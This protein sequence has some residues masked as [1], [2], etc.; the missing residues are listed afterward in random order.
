MP[1][2]IQKMSQQLTDKWGELNKGQ[3]T[4]IGILSLVVVSIIAFAIYFSTRS[5]WVK[6]ID[7]APED[8]KVISEKLDEKKIVYTL[9]EDA[10]EIY[11]KEKDKDQAILLL[12][13][14]GYPKKG[15]DLETLITEESDLGTTTQ[16]RTLKHQKALQTELERMIELYPQVDK[17][18]VQLVLAEES[19]FINQDEES[20]AAV[21]L[22]TNQ[23]LTTKE[24]NG[25]AHLIMSSVKALN[26]ENINIVANGKLLFGE[27]QDPTSED[28]DQRFALQKAKE[29]DIEKKVKEVL[30]GYDDVKVAAQLKLDFDK[31]KDQTI[32]YEPVNKD[33]GE[34][35]VVEESK[36]KE[37]LINGDGSVPAGVTQNPGATPDMYPNGQNSQSTYKKDDQKTTRVWNE[38]RTEVDKAIG[39]VISDESSVAVTVF[40][41][42]TYY[43]EELEKSGELQDKSWETFQDEVKST[44]KTLPVDAGV[45]DQIQK[46]TGIKDVNVVIKERPV[47]VAKIEKTIPVKDY[48]S[49]GVVLLLIIL[50]GIFII[51]RNQPEEEFILTPDI[52][53]DE[54]LEQVEN[55]VPVEEIDYDE[56]GSEVK[57]QIDK[58]VE[59]KPEA[60]AQ[61]LRN[62]LNEDWE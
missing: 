62:W 49:M 60:V 55:T 53:V 4:K 51:R 5:P 38:K 13:E 10:K 7:A 52:V 15:Y 47:F 54:I 12:A 33:T 45:I 39:E 27:D 11:V 18:T 20:K 46:A 16:E 17:A 59:E 24:A 1:E 35:A 41:D 28:V 50:L 19:D 56:E 32:N 42:K 21:Y 36:S 58:F 3:K 6:L 14:A 61:L 34:G 57:K 40:R 37:E 44:E 22:E 2:A 8:S 23:S 9:K 30:T 31:Q 25:I 29:K 43:Q 48:V 26:K